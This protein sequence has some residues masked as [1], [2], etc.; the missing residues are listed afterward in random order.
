[1]SG[2]PIWKQAENA[3]M[4]RE[5]E[6]ARVLEISKQFPGALS[7]HGDIGT[8]VIHAGVNDIS[9]HQSEALKEHFRLL[10]ETFKKRAKA[11]VIIS[12][13]L[14]TYRRGSEVFSTLYVLHC[15]LQG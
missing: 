14:P 7:K 4:A 15:W 1:M 11:R 12:G 9:S 3:S 8:I 6:G 5:R 13:P 2:K 10:L